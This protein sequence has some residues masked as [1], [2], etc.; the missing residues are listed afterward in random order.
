MSARGKV[1]FGSRTSPANL[2]R[3]HQPPNEKKAPTMPPAKAPSK[4]SDPGRWAR[5]GVKLDHC[6]ARNPKPQ[7]ITK[8]S[9]PS[10]RIVSQRI[11]QPPSLTPRTLTTATK[12]IE[13]MATAFETIGESL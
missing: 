10:L 8:A 13:P 6:P 1:F 9:S 2:L 11:N 5:R 12:T 4:G 3:S 7:V